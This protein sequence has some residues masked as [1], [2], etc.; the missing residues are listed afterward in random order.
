M[1]SVLTAAS[2]AAALALAAGCSSASSGGPVAVGGRPSSSPS[3]TPTGAG[4]SGVVTNPWLPLTPG[5]RWVYRGYDGG[6]ATRDVQTIDTKTKLIN[7]IEATIAH[8]NLYNA[9]TGRIV[10]RT[11]DWYAQD[12]AGNV[13]Y[14]GEDTAEV[15]PD[16]TV[17]S[18]GGSW[19]DGRNGAHRGIIMYA[20]PQVGASYAQEAFPGKAEDHAQ[21]LSLTASVRTPAAHSAAALETKEWSPLEAHVIE[22][23][24]YIR[25]VG[26]TYDTVVKGPKE[27]SRLVSYTPGH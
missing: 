26:D 10:E 3:S 22:H 24:Y 16:G 13:W 27:F 11:D 14:M 23:K 15:K 6:Q 2:A 19:Q 25:G 5:S 21:V 7:G 8:D 18:H 1:R 20:D 9:R 12:S 4:W 17:K